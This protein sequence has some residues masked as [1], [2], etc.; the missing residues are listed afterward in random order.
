MKCTIKDVA[1]EARV[2]IATVSRVINNQDKV[3]SST[4]RKVEAAIKKLQFNPNQIARTLINGETKSVGLIVPHLSNDYWSQVAEVIQEELWQL[5]YTVMLCT[6]SVVENPVEREIAFLKNFINRNVDGIIFGTLRDFSSFNHPD[7]KEILETKEVSIVA[8]DQRIPGI[9]SV[10]GDH[11]DGAQIAV[12]HLI[13]L[14]HKQIAYIGGTLLNPDREL[15]YR[16]AHVIKNLAV[17]ESIIKR[18]SATFD[19][20]YTSMVELLTS[21]EEFTA[22]FCGNDLIAVGAL[23]AIESKGLKVPEDVA[24]V[25]YDDI[26]IS[27]MI[28]PA[29]TTIRQPI[30]EMAKSAVELL[31][32]MIETRETIEI[33]PK[34]LMFQMELIIRESAGLLL[35]KQLKK[36]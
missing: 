22:L 36:V 11:M 8:F 2:S 10:N 29:L 12:K 7:I 24:I 26:N 27:T 16:N 13:E 1:K 30:K 9:S 33:A 18:G 32:E 34:N 31:V 23:Q 21:N 3:K 17:N 6:T 20:G 19:F 15:G 35:K 5:G 25:G 14:G 28:K 4:R